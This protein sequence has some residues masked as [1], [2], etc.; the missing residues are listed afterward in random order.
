[1][2]SRRGRRF[3]Q[4][5]PTLGDV[6]EA[7]LLSSLTALASGGADDAALWRSPG[8]TD[9]ALS[10]DCLVEGVDYRREWIGPHQLGRRAL[11]VALSDL[12]G[13][14]AV[15]A[16][17]L[18]TLCAPARTGLEDVLAIQE[19]L[20]DAARRCGCRLIGGDVSDTAGPLVIDVSVA[21]TVAPG[22]ALLRDA[23]RPGDALVVTGHLGRAAAGLELLRDPDAR[24]RRDGPGGGWVEAQLEPAARLDEGRA[25]VAAGVRC[26][27]DVSD[28][29]LVDIER[30]A[31]ASDCAAELWLDSLPV[32]PA[33]RRA[34]GDRW[35]ALALA[36]GEDFELAAA[37]PPELLG[38][39]ISGWP[40]ALAPLAV[41]GRLLPGSGVS[42]LR[43][44]GGPPVEPPAISSRHYG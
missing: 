26:A 2:E 22:R 36:G 41:V 21:G 38:P 8:D 37:V 18:A 28:G 30:T 25:L 12:A 44:R 43:R 23:G 17:A 42:L 16:Y 24:S 13:M 35:P 15:P 5:G 29:L 7:R 3:D 31:A 19:G 34:F 6:G 9:L 32:E 14:G 27:G 33:L 10:Q 39:L 1:M 20:C 40:P 11:Q 4:G